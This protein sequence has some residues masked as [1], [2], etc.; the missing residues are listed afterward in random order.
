MRAL[1]FLTAC[2]ALA[3][4]GVKWGNIPLS[5]E[6]NTGQTTTDVRYLARGSAY[7]LYLGSGETVL[8]ARNQSPLRTKLLGANPSA[9]IL[10][11]S[12]QESTSNY[13]FGKDPSK[14]RTGVPNYG[15]IRYTGLYP[16]IDLVFYGNEAKL[17]YDWIVSPGAY[18][19]KI[20]LIF[21][22]ADQLRNRQTGR[23]RDQT[24]QERIPA[25]ETSGLSGSR[26]P[27]RS[28]CRQLG[29]ARQRR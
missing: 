1:F 10:G 6:P 13:F 27:T 7:T 16:G 21:D 24:G 25:P 8:A 2:T 11:E 15:R 5:F 26:G 28:G 9:R 3:A 17:E 23:S 14:W 19:H 22:G 29:F 20:R 18:P 12:Q 4:P